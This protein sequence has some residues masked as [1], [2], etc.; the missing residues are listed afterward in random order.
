MATKVQALIDG[1]WENIPN[2]SSQGQSSKALNGMGR[3]NFEIVEATQHQLDNITR[4]TP[5]RFVDAD[6]TI[7]GI[8]RKVDGNNNLRVEGTDYSDLANNKLLRASELNEI[9]TG[10][11][12][13][14]NVVYTDKEF[15]L[16]VIDIATA[17]GLTA[18]TDSIDT[19]GTLNI[20]FKRT[21]GIEA[22][23]ELARQSGYEWIV[24]ND[25][26]LFMKSRLGSTDAVTS[27]NLGGNATLVRK[28]EDEERRCTR[29]VVFGSGGTSGQAEDST[30]IS[31]GEIY[32]GRFKFDALSTN[33]MCEQRAEEIVKEFKDPILILVLNTFTTGY[34]LGDTI[35][36]RG[37]K[38]TEDYRITKV[39]LNVGSQREVDVTNQ[40]RKHRTETPDEVMEKL[41]KGGSQDV[42]VI[43]SGDDLQDL[44]YT[45]A[46]VAGP[47]R[48]FVFDFNV[49]TEGVTDIL[50]AELFTSRI[51]A[52]SL[53]GTETGNS[54][55]GA[56]INNSSQNA[57]HGLSNS[58]QNA[59]VGINNAEA[60]APS[61]GY[62]FG[63]YNNSLTGNNSW[64]SMSAS[65][66]LSNTP[67]FFHSIFGSLTLQFDAGAG[68]SWSNL[69]RIRA[70]NTSTGELFPGS[71]G[72]EI[73]RSFSGEGLF[74]SILSFNLF[75]PRSW[76][77]QGYTLQYRIENQ[78]N[79]SGLN[80]GRY[81]YYGSRGH[82]HSNSTT[83]G[84]HTHSNS[85]TGGNHTHSNSFSDEN[86]TNPL[87]IDLD[88]FDTA[89][90]I[91]A[92]VIVN[93]TSA[94]NITL[95]SF[96]STENIDISEYVTSAGNQQIVIKPDNDVALSTNANI[97][98]FKS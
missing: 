19:F 58:S 94:G 77:N 50:K 55:T 90:S 63:S 79:W 15:R 10:L 51:R 5:I 59:G 40:D 87:S 53:Y 2:V 44:T 43:T 92:E 78:N 73:A 24:D 20:R 21:Y 97:K 25:K 9:D 16:I 33:A 70:R 6:L 67:Y 66:N 49:D 18:D 69:I 8:A 85:I 88:E 39:T 31:D 81:G 13:G 26:K 74:T 30:Y 3:F 60:G 1:T 17:M 38:G 95:S 84:N 76:Q 62:F 61:T 48:D 36:L 89:S 45:G 72:L 93:G 71:D 46:D 96:G 23:K 91:T 52:A 54:F 68:S 98:I 7:E 42:S 86:H 28:E 11:S 56:A 12:S 47:S 64:N 29:A 34:D 75:I 65:V 41:L 37:R 32:E 57:G 82:T 35:T 14:Y 80:E 83:G 4:G 27:L 22:L